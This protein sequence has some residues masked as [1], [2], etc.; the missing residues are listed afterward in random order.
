MLLMLP[1]HPIQNQTFDI[2]TSQ[3][4]ITLLVVKCASWFILG[5]IGFPVQSSRYKK[6]SLRFKRRR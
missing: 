1:H 5:A 3:T 4:I 6:R 2:L